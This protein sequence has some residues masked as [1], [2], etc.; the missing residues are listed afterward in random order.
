MN[1]GPP[2]VS[3]LRTLFIITTAYEAHTVATYRHSYWSAGQTIGWSPLRGLSRPSTAER[4][5]NP[6]AQ[7]PNNGSRAPVGPTVVECPVGN[8]APSVST[9][10]VR[11]DTTAPPTARSA[12]FASTSERLPPTRR[13]T[14]SAERPLDT[15]RYQPMQCKGR[16]YFFSLIAALTLAAMSGGMAIILCAVLACSAP[17]APSAPRERAK[18]TGRTTAQQRGQR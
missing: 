16:V 6:C 11:R 10:C 1:V 17:L 5:S 14:P 7:A 13:S 18:T 4:R 9:G 3:A 12:P 8:C 15:R 2:I